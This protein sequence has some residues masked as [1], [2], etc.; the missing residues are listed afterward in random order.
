MRFDLTDGERLAKGPTGMLERACQRSA[1]GAS[2]FGGIFLMPPAAVSA[3][4]Q[5]GQRIRWFRHK[6]EKAR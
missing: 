5:I 2:R 3:R 6:P 4:Q 1:S